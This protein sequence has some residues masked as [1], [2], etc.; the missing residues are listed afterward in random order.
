LIKNLFSHPDLVRLQLPSGWSFWNGTSHYSEASD[1][2]ITVLD[3]Y[4]LNPGDLSWEP[5]R[6]FGECQIYDRTPLEEV[7]PH[8]AGSEIILT[9]KTLVSRAS[10]EKLPKA[11]YIGV[12]ATGY[13]IV[14]IDAARER[15]ITVT[16]VPGYATSS[17]AQM[18]FAHLLNLTLGLG[19]HMHSVREG[20]WAK[21]EDFCFWQTPLIELS[22]MTM[23]IVGYGQI[24]RATAQLARAFGM[25]VIVA[26][27]PGAKV[28]TEQGIQQMSLS[29][30]F[31][32]SDVVSLHCPLTAATKGLVN[33]DRLSL[34]KSSA[35]LINTSRGP[36]IDEPALAHALQEGRIAGA[37]LDVLS[38]EP[39]P[40]DHPL[41]LARN[42][43]ITPH[44]AWATREARGR[45]LSVV[46]GNI[47]AF[48]EG[49][50]Q[51]CV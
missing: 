25:N 46:I 24:G 38:V 30:L 21:A 33:N 2:R 37:G 27:R 28:A 39:P 26:E 32:L 9:N 18:V 42:C 17:V 6:N 36:L 14:D 50:P 8:A 3:G 31:R 16:N 23:G 12:L 4:T 34:M 19:R 49:H 43:Y 44:I 29:D 35:F 48:L 7:V 1:M 41:V 45:L 51:N 11:R 5:L 20:D 10:L 15:G 22:G 13:N 47:K 40:P